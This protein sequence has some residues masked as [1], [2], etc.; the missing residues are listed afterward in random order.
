MYNERRK[1]KPKKIRF[2]Y[3]K[4]IKEINI[5]IKYTDYIIKSLPKYHIYLDMLTHRYKK[6][7]EPET[8]KEKNGK[9]DEQTYRCENP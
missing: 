6:M 1:P 7:N 3:T 4:S 2:L 9:K 5:Q 8:K